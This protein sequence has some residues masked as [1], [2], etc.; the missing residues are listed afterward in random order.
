MLNGDWVQ[1]RGDGAEIDP[2]QVKIFDFINV[3]HKHNTL[4]ADDES[5]Y[6]EGKQPYNYTIQVKWD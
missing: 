2:T 3:K 5:D 6:D 1:I 4:Y